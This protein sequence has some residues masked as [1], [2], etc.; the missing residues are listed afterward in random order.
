MVKPLVDC[1]LDKASKIRTSS[2]EI[3]VEVMTYTG[4]E[5]FGK[6][7]ANLKTAV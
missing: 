7:V 1:L 4:Y 3:I 2:E 6:V 5:P